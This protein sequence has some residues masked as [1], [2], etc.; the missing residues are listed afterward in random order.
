MAGEIWDAVVIGAGQA[1]LATGYHLRRAGLR[2]VT[3]EAGAQVGGSWPC[4]YDSL[5]LFSP[6]RYSSLPGL[7][8]PGD[9]DHYPARAEVVNYLRR[10]AAYFD[11]P[12]VLNSSVESVRREGEAFEVQTAGGGVYRGRAVVAATG[13]FRDLTDSL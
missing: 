2:F 9:S 6:A 8:F 4:Y 7:P 12:V 13:S 1:G 5:R 3:L 10:Y 11:R